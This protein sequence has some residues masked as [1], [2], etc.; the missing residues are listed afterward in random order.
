M[1]QEAEVSSVL[2]LKQLRA[3]LGTF[4]ATAAAAL[5][6]AG[7]E[8]QRTRHWL[9]EDRYR[10]WRTQLQVRTTR[11]AQAKIALNQK[12]VF[13][14]TL[15]GSPTSCVDERRALRVA[16]AQLRE[17]EHKLSRVRA[18]SQRIDKE[19]SNYQGA[20]QRLLSALEVEIP[21]ARAKLDKMIGSLEAYLALAPP[22]MARAA[23]GESEVELVRPEEA[24]VPPAAEPLRETTPAPPEKS[25]PD[26]EREAT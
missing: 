4:A 7:T 9:G 10:Y 2:V 13:D 6:E 22:E 17:A 18:W 11:F 8:I 15:A 19:M 12:Q 14:R 3:S 25:A 21:N 20:T 5:E 23:P 26:P 1:R 24:P 16:E